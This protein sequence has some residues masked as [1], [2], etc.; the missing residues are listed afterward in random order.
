MLGNLNSALANVQQKLH[1]WEVVL[2]SRYVLD[3]EVTDIAKLRKDD[4][5]QEMLESLWV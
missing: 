1:N 2:K 4:K 3:S 5:F